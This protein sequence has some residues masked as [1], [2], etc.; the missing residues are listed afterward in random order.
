MG[1]QTIS[2]PPAPNVHQKS[3]LIS[4]QGSSGE[5]YFSFIPILFKTVL[6]WDSGTLPVIALLDSGA[7]ENLMDLDLVSQ[8]KI[9]TV[10]LDVPILARS[11]N[12]LSLA[13]QFLLKF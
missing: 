2:L 4:R 13:R 8:L 9:P 10:L 7:D 1:V 6:R 12:G 5:S 11:L 3:R